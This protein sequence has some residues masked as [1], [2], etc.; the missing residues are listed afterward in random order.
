[1]MKVDLHIHSIASGHALNTVSEIV[2]YAEMCGMSHIAIT[3]HGPDMEGAPHEGYFEVSDMVS[4]NKSNIKIYMGV[5]ANILDADGTID[6]HEPYLAMQRI[7]SAGIHER[8]S[9][10]GR[11][12]QEHTDSLLSVIEEKKC[13]IITHPW[14][15]QF[16]IDIDVVAKAAMK[17]GVLLELNDRIFKYPTFALIKAYSKMINIIKKEGGFLIIGSDSHIRENIGNDSNVLAVKEEL[18]LVPE[19]VLNN[20]PN[21]MEEMLNEK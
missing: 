11:R 19:I 10:V 2:S 1:M 17:Q 6:I 14:R 18:G 5:E 8:T 3:D 13:Q 12:L 21:I 9:Y 16:P 15:E 20:Y 7:I 4:V